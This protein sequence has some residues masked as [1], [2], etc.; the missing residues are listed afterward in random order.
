V[1]DR[2][3]RQYFENLISRNGPSKTACAD[4]LQLLAPDLVEK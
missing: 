4:L 2:P 3:T 1:T